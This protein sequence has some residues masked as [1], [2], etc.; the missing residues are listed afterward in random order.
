M[1]QGPLKETY[2]KASLQVLSVKD[3]G[4]ML[5]QPSAFPVLLKN[6]KQEDIVTKAGDTPFAREVL[7]F[8]PEH[9]PPMD[10]GHA[11]SCRDFWLQVALRDKKEED[12]VIIGLKFMDMGNGLYD[13]SSPFIARITEDLYYRATFGHHIIERFEALTHD[14]MKKTQRPAPL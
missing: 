1:T 9:Y 11:L 4:Q 2:E 3:L 7:K 10:D 8:V 5:E 13:V 6:F 12:N 14:I